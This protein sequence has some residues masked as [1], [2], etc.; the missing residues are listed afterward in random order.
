MIRSTS[1]LCTADQHRY[2]RGEPGLRQLQ[3]LAGVVAAG[4][5]IR[6][7]DAG[8]SRGEQGRTGQLLL[9]RKVT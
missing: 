7:G 8:A 3:A 4:W 2:D 5:Q 1:L 9:I 6:G